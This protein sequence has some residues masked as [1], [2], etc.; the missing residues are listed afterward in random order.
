L[1]VASLLPDAASAAEPALTLEAVKRAPAKVV[2]AEGAETPPEVKV[3]RDWSGPLCRS[4]IVNEGKKPIRV[5]E[6]VLFDL[7]HVLPP[8]AG[9]YGEGFT[10]QSMT[11]GT[12]GKPIQTGMNFGRRAKTPQPED[13]ILVHGLLGLHPAEGVHILLAFTSCH[14]FLGRFVIRPKSI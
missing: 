12:L 3:V 5:K 2:P 6:I 8:E 7:P 1:V 14:R 4:R 9:L 13:A 11:T 10:M